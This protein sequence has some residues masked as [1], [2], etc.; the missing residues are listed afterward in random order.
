MSSYLVFI[1]SRKL[2]ANGFNLIDIS[3]LVSIIVRVASVFSAA[4]KYMFNNILFK[5]MHSVFFPT[6]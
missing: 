4:Y 5:S 3:S 2:K 1:S 6:L